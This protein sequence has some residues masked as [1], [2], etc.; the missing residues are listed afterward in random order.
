MTSRIDSKVL[1]NFMTLRTMISGLDRVKT[2]PILC[3]LHGDRAR[4]RTCFFSRHLIGTAVELLQS[5]A[6]HLQFHLRI[7][8]EDLRVS[9]AKHLCY[10]LVRYPSGTEPR[11]IGRAEIVDAE[12]RHLG[13]PQGGMPG[14][15]Q[16]SLMS[17]RVLIARKQIR[18]AWR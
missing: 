17:A 13:A 12:V 11:G 8:L 16:S 14:A 3:S 2:V 9:L 10:P 7:L 6:L 5:L 18:T 15:F 4:M 1:S